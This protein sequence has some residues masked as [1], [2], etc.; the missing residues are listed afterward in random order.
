MWSGNYELDA[1]HTTLNTK[2]SCVQRLLIKRANSCSSRGLSKKITDT[3]DFFS[4]SSRH[5]L[6]YANAFH[7]NRIR[8]D[9]FLEHSR[10]VS[11]KK[12]IDF[13]TKIL[14][15]PLNLMNFLQFL[16]EIDQNIEN[17]HQI[18]Q[19][20]EQAPK[21]WLAP[22]IL[23]HNSSEK[24]SKNKKCLFLYKKRHFSWRTWICPLSGISLMCI[25]FGGSSS[26]EIQNR[27][28]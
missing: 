20:S 25:F 5:V 27:W 12:S 19:N 14:N 10:A 2:I 11:A 6:L 28:N 4:E 23:A 18:F 15:F 13:R 21:N 26:L 3:R 7:R 24:Y 9:N 22:Q 8:G 17:P 1:T 16:K